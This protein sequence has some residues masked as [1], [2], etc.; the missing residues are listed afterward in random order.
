MD[1]QKR[2]NR[3]FLEKMILCN[4][5]DDIDTDVIDFLWDND[6]ENRQVIFK[7][8][9]KSV[10][11][12]CLKEKNIDIREFDDDTRIFL[13][14]NFPS[15]LSDDDISYCI[16]P[17]IRKR[18]SMIIKLFCKKTRAFVQWLISPSSFI[19]TKTKFL[20][21]GSTL[22]IIVFDFL[23]PLAIKKTQEGDLFGNIIC[24]F[25]SKLGKETFIDSDTLL[26]YDISGSFTRET[27]NDSDLMYRGGASPTYLRDLK[28][29]VFNN[30]DF[31][32]LELTKEDVELYFQ[33]IMDLHTS[34]SPKPTVENEEKRS[35]EK[36]WFMK[37]F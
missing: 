32:F 23:L 6:A 36:S 3:I 30:L 11:G 13:L 27:E 14:E 8:T 22:P 21:V 5:T 20:T 35:C 16:S 2:I 34:V 18:K 33:K 31:E 1:V 19:N 25:A 15:F 9:Q 17:F 12:Y 29:C 10:I 24:L 26:S 4:Y 7:S 37:L 28:M